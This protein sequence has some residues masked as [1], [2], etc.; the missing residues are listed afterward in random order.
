MWAADVHDS[1]VAL[2]DVLVARSNTPELVGRA[3]MFA[4]SPAGVVAT[5]LTFRIRPHRNVTSEYLA[6]YL[7]FLYI[8]GYWRTRAGGASGSMKKITQGQVQAQQVP[9]PPLEAE[10]DRGRLG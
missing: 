5:D 9:L 6:G 7:S 4:G 3:A 1:S 10:A 2:G 8:S